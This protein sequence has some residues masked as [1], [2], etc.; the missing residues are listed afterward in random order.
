MQLIIKVFTALIFIC[1]FSLSLVFA[2]TILTR[3]GQSIQAKITEV[4]E[5]T[6]WYEVER[7]DIVEEVGIDISEVERIFD[8]DGN[9]SKYSPR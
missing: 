3:E 2:E 7:G 4:T 6:V 8:D 9:V 1:V 5:D